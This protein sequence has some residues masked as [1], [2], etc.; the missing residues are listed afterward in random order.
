MRFS[1]NPPDKTTLLYKEK[2]LELWIFQGPTR[3][4]LTVWQPGLP[5]PCR[6]LP[7][8]G[9]K[10]SQSLASVI[11][12]AP[13]RQERWKRGGYGESNVLEQLF[14]QPRTLSHPDTGAQGSIL[15]TRQQ[16]WQVRRQL[17]VMLTFLWTS[18]ARR[19]LHFKGGTQEPRRKINGD[20]NPS[21]TFLWTQQEPQ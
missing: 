13:L 7:S 21:F 10:Q 3:L 11:K 1:L 18:P 19:W 12:V 4:S 5:L 6:Q 15:D 16:D 14:N 20:R 8:T 2:W 9:W 17:A